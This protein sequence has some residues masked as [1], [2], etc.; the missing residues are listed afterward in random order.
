VPYPTKHVFGD[1]LKCL[2]S[3]RELQ[4]RRSSVDKGGADPSLEALNASA[5]GRLRGIA[6]FSGTRKAVSFGKRNEILKQL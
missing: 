6:P 2:A 1:F 3:C 4:W 5:K